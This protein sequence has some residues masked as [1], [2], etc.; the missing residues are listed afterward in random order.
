MLG[1]AESGNGLEKEHGLKS[2][3]ACQ[4]LPPGPGHWRHFTSVT[5]SNLT[6]G[7]ATAQSDFLWGAKIN[8]HLWCNTYCHHLQNIEC[9]LLKCQ[10]HW[11][12]M[13]FI[14]AIRVIWLCLICMFFYP[15]WRILHSYK[16]R[17]L[18]VFSLIILLFLM[19]QNMCL[20]PELM[21][22]IIFCY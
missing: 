1:R 12:N 21:L 13:Q 5:R 8:C 4:C 6:W 19:L 18:P 15:P 7:D 2:F 16:T 3:S 14:S 10:C 9:S 20:V 11:E 17:K 22:M